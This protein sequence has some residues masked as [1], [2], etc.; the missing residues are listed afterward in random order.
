MDK[1]KQ[2]SEQESLRIIA[3]MIQLVKKDFYDTGISAL[4][5]GTVVGF[6]GLFC[7][8][9]ISFNWDFNYFFVWNLTFIALLPQIA[10]AITERRRRKAKENIDTVSIIWIVFALI[11]FGLA[12]YTSVLKTVPSP[13]SLYLL[14]YTI[15]TLTTGIVRK[16]KAV[17][18]GGFICYICFIIS[19]FTSYKIDMLLQSIA[20]IS[21]WLIPGLIL[22]HR[23]IKS[24]TKHV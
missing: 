19:C 2:L 12:L 6:C 8:L 10:I 13:S 20:A 16:F 4:M 21:A 18:I 14:V 11:M 5:W 23:Y 22:R 9:G 1:E 15:P 7:F 3:E 17:I 24:T